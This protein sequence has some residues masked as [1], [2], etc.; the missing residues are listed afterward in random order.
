MP[1]SRLNGCQKWKERKERKDRILGR[2][3][4]TLSFTQE[5]RDSITHLFSKC[6]AFLTLCEY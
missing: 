4:N 5:H 6:D 1:N 3:K 2:Q